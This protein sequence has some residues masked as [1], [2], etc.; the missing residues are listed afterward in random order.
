[1]RT[2]IAAI[3]IALLLSGA[4]YFYFSNQIIYLKSQIATMNDQVQKADVQVASINSLIHNFSIYS[5][6][7][8]LCVTYTD[9]NAAVITLSCNHADQ[10]WEMVPPNQ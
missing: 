4:G 8:S 1:M 6:T 2:A 5:K 10:G 7:R 3:I 9:D